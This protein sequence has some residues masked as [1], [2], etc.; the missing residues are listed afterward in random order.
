[1]IKDHDNYNCRITT[2]NGEQHLVYANWIHNQGLDTWQGYHC[3]AGHT[4]LLIDN[5]FDVWSGECKNKTGGSPD[6]SLLLYQ[7]MN[8]LIFLIFNSPLIL[9]IGVTGMSFIFQNFN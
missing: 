9:A 8:L 4:R 7:P 6:K 5:N 2:D 1:M 3:D